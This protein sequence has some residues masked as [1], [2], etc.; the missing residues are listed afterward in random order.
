MTQLP[1]LDLELR[2]KMR[3]TGPSSEQRAVAPPPSWSRRFT[4]AY[5]SASIQF[6]P[7]YIPSANNKEADK[8]LLADGFQSLYPG[9]LMV[10]RDVSAADWGRFLEDIIVAGRLTGKQSLISNVAPITMHI[11]IT[12]F[13][14]TRAIEK[15]MK[16]RKNPLIYETVEAWQQNFFQ[17]RN[18]DVYVIHNGQRRTARS[19]NGPIPASTSPALSYPALPY[20]AMSNEFRRSHTSSSSSSSSSLSSDSSN[21]GKQSKPLRKQMKAERKHERKMAKIERKHQR[22]IAKIERKHKRQQIKYPGMP[23]L[24]PGPYRAA[25]QSVIPSPATSSCAVLRQGYYLVT[26]PLPATS[27]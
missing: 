14:V 25:V 26:A 10:H 23:D 6:E 5:T 4:P 17:S 12:G 1:Q 19:P 8:Q 2:L 27:W 3:F 20:P 16:K 11:G 15:G 24:Q 18:L 7:I 13:L 9:R 22:K 21:D